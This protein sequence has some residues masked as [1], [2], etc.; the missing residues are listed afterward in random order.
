M[1]YAMPRESF[2]SRPRLL[3]LFCGAGGATKGYQR[4][5]FYVVGVDIKPQPHYCG[6]EFYQADALTYPLEGFDA[7]HASP[8]CQRYSTMTKKWG[9]QEQHPDL[10]APVREELEALE[11]PFVVENVEGAPLKNP[12]MLCGSMFGLGAI[13]EYHCDCGGFPFEYEL[14]KYGCPNCCGGKVARLVNKY[15]LRR[16]RLF[17]TSWGYVFPPASCAHS[18]LALPVYGHAGGQS[19]R[20]G[21]KFPGTD[22]WR[23][24]MGIDWM[25][26]KELA[27]AIPPAFTEY[28]GKF[29]MA[30]VMRI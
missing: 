28:I 21:L 11:V 18:G 9:R 13:P 7:Y 14:G 26:G 19:K 17:E 27:E 22:A 2:P 24:G 15:Q 29:L 6:D 25:T 23:E 16:H 4:A 8:P 1:T 12:T 3:D 30:E 5:G 10:I 20:D